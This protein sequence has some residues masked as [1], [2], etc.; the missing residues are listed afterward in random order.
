MQETDKNNTSAIEIA[1]PKTESLQRLPDP[2]PMALMPQSFEQMLKVADVLAKSGLVPK[3]YQGR[4]ADVF[5]A[6]QFGAELGM[7]PF[8]AVRNIDVIEGRP[9][10]RARASMGVCI[11]EPDCEYFREHP[12]SVRGHLS[13]WVCKRRG[14]EHRG[15]FSIDEAKTAG[16]LGKDN[17]KKYPAQMLENRAMMFAARKAYPDKL[18]GVYMPD[19]IIEMRETAPNEF[20]APTPATQIV[21]VEPELAGPTA[22]EICDALNE[23]I[24]RCTTTQQVSELLPECQALRDLSP[25]L[26]KQTRRVYKDQLELI[27]HAARTEAEA[28]Q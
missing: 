15:E 1:K 27:E 20:A 14:V 17:W 19:E 10:L 23:R 11:V 13:I 21:D 24:R 26:A 25:E 28:N 6:M 5:G 12:D 16:L 4:P 22:L 9:A 2:K 3:A 7:M 8:A 18:S